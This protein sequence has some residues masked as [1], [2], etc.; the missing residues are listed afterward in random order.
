MCQY[1]QALPYKNKCAAKDFCRLAYLATM[2]DNTIYAEAFGEGYNLNISSP[3]L[4]LDDLQ[5][6]IVNL[7]Y[8]D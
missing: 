8:T 5:D 4:E 6:I 1:A 2:D 3:T 7:R